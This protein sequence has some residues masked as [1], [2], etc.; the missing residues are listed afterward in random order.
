MVN[1][2]ELASQLALANNCILTGICV[3]ESEIFKHFENSFVIGDA[4]K[5]LSI[6]QELDDF[7]KFSRDLSKF[8]KVT[9]RYDIKA[10]LIDI[11]YV[12]DRDNLV[13][14][15]LLCDLVVINQAL[16]E[17]YVSWSPSDVLI[18]AEVP[19]LLIPRMWKG[20]I[21]NNIIVDWKWERNSKRA[22]SE[23]MSLLCKA[24]RVELVSL[25]L[26]QESK[27]NPKLKSQE[28]LSHL[29]AHNIQAT[30]EST[31]CAGDSP[32]QYLLQYA[33][34]RNCDLLVIG[35]SRQSSI[36]DK[37]FGGINKK[38]IELTDIPL[39]ISS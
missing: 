5:E 7:Q 37:L 12:D 14:R 3:N 30:F 31:V 16:G 27:D 24:R 34:V 15:F 26:N 23:S 38:I 20:E 13:E 11:N 4:V 1:T 9:G 32:A 2:L 21:A 17:S 29:N 8:Q 39:F 18:K 10:K 19:I 25:C 6:K 33:K 35:S 22:L 28:V 36:I